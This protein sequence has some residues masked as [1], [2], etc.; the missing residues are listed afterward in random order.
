M[1]NIYAIVT[2]GAFKGVI[3]EIVS[4]EMSMCEYTK[5]ILRV[6]FDNEITVLDRQVKPLREEEY[7]RIVLERKKEDMSFEITGI[8]KIYFSV[9][10]NFDP[11]TIKDVIFNDPA[12]I[13]LWEDGS[14]TVV[15]CQEGDTYNKETGLAMAIIKK[16]CSNKGNYNDIF[17]KWIKE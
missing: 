15:K 4:V 2:S 17:E 6:D 11:S 9:I 7:K 12:T 14:K 5:V 3:G 8:E 13:V 1:I 10:N 16:C